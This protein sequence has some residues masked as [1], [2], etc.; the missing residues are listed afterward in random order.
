M[1]LIVWVLPEIATLTLF[2]RNDN[3]QYEIAT[4]FAVLAA[5]NDTIN[6][7]PFWMKRRFSRDFELVA[8]L[9]G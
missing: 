5:R 9:W 7:I 3:L 6:I 8:I 1:Q 4:P 2:A